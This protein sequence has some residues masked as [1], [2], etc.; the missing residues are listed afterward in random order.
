MENDPLVSVVIP[1]FN[2]AGYVENAVR[3]ILN[4]SYKNLE[5]IIVDDASTDD[6]LKILNAIKDPRIIVI[7]LKENTQKVLAVN[8]AL[9]KAKGDFIA[10]QDAD[11]WSEEVR[12]E[13]QMKFFNLFPS[14][15]IC[16]TGYR[17]A[18]DK[19]HQD[20]RLSLTD[21]ELRDEFIMFGRRK[22]GGLS[23]T[24]CA[25]MMITREVLNKT[26]GYHPFFSGRVAEDIHWVY[27]ILK[28][29]KGS[30]V[31]KI[32]YNINQREGSLTEKQLNGK[33]AKAAY[34]W[35]LLSKIIYR[36]YEKNID[37]LEP[38][39][40]NELRS[41]ELEA[42]EEELVERIFLNNKLQTT[43]E[44]S[45]RYRLGKLL[46]SPYSY[47]KLIKHNFFDYLI[48]T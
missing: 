32:L 47:L 42:C 5:V 24:M 28:E 40:E 12:I 20:L 16:F 14:L 37:V 38:I 26:K 8:T 19:L 45:M 29:F 18:T 4:Q 11:D 15:G 6:T 48:S 30:T 46:L 3:S 17:Y 31:N 1:C 25:T 9:Q 21:E 36:D 10:F 34:T 44:T 22:L 2:V 13:E 7:Q 41:L 35:K 43:Y 27:R 33:N 39:Y 23:P